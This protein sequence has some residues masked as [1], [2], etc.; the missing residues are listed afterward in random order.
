MQCRNCGH[1]N[2]PEA[3]FCANCGAPLVP[4]V[5]RPSAANISKARRRRILIWGLALLVIGI[6]CVLS[7]LYYKSIYDYG[8]VTYEH[9]AP[10]ATTSSLVPVLSSPANGAILDNGRTDGRDE[11][12]WDFDWSDV[13]D[14]TK[15]EI[16]I[17]HFQA[18]NS[19]GIIIDHLLSASYSQYQYSDVAYYSAQDSSWKWK[20]RAMVKGQ[21]S[22][23]SEERTFDLEPVNTDPAK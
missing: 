10:T 19:I 12:I 1:D 5:E 22:E 23:W 3:D 15:Y 16:A 4:N 6:F 2:L 9:P 13:A 20:V 21:W 8:S 18:N 14:A 7:Y 17:I 11:I